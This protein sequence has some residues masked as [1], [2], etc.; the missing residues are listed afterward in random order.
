MRTNFSCSAANHCIT[1]VEVDV[2]RGDVVSKNIHETLLF[3]IHVCI[4]STSLYTNHV[5]IRAGTLRSVE[6]DKRGAENACLA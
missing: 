3:F 5:M 4:K 6:A 2:G 1:D